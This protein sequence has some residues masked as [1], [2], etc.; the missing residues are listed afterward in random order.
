[1][2]EEIRKATCGDANILTSIAF[3]AK[4][5][6]NYP[7]QYFEIWEKELTITDSYI[8]NNI[9]FVFEKVVIQGFYSIVYLQEDLYLNNILVNKGYWMDHL[10]VL[11]DSQ[12]KGIGRSLFSHA[13]TYC[14]KKK[15][16]SLRIFV[17]PNAVTFYEKMGAQYC[18]DSPSSI[19]GRVVPI[20]CFSIKE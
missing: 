11:P 1:M 19:P 14:A 7:E 13:I 2:Y 8:E 6:W 5:T 17:D 4:R 15:V 12:N 10:F 9:V 20:Y 3:A 16:D 18:K